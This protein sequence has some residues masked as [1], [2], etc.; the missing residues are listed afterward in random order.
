MA[1]FS[2]LRKGNKMS[3]NNTEFV[4]LPDGR[5]AVIIDPTKV[6]GETKGGHNSHAKTEGAGAQVAPNFYIQVN[7]WSRKPK[8]APT[9][10]LVPVTEVKF[11]N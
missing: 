2:S 9:S 8:P 6:I 7:A 11:G 3:V 5:Y 10:K 1:I 4:R